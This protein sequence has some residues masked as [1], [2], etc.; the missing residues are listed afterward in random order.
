M[1]HR[2]SQWASLGIGRTYKGRNLIVKNSVL[3]MAWYL[4][5]SQTIPDL[6]T[7][8]TTW[9]SM[10][11]HFVESSSLSLFTGAQTGTAHHVARVVLVQDYPEGGR[12]CLDVELF[13]R[14]LRARIVRNLFETSAHPFQNLAF[15]W[16]RRSYPVMNLML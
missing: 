5:E 15:Y 2:F 13:V 16:I 14:A 6:D 7:I 1:S 9:Q 8:L 3:A 12:R 4:T 11:W 10:A